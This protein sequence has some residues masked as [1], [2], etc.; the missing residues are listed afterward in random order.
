MY[1]VELR[2]GR[3]IEVVMSAPMDLAEVLA[4]EAKAMTLLRATPAARV[5]LAIDMKN[6]HVF[7]EP[8][9]E[10][11]LGFIRE[12]NP[13]IERAAFLVNDSSVLAMQIGRILRAA[14]GNSRRIFREASEMKSW[15]GEPLSVDERLRLG[16]FLLKR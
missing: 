12:K 16:M 9:A 1:S 3:L 10:T 4:L 6:A 15:L 7:S 13:R 11:L 2:T 8:A 5:V 14:G